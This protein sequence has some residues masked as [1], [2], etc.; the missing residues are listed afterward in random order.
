MI[1]LNGDW[2]AVDEPVAKLLCEVIAQA[3][4]SRLFP[5]R[6]RVDRFS[7]GGVVGHVLTK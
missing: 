2:L 6:L 3:G 4:D 5:G 7:V 1:R